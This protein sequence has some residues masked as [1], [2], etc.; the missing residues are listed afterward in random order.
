MAGGGKVGV[1]E[2]TNSKVRTV[3]LDVSHEEKSN[4]SFKG[5]ELTP[6][7]P[8]FSFTSESQTHSSFPSVG[9]PKLLS[10]CLC[11][12]NHRIC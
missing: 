1:K 12:P 7:S 10:C 9:S 8:N 11:F 6:T 5:S 2:A 4:M 3:K